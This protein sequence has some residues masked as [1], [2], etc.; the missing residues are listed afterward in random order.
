MRQTSLANATEL[1]VNMR[2][3]ISLLAVFV[4]AVLVA[5]LVTFTAGP[6]TMRILSVAFIVPIISLSLAFIYYCRKRKVWSYAGASV[7]EQ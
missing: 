7:W 2:T 1:S 3:A 6:V 5:F 4:V